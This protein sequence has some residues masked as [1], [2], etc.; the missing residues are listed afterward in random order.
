MNYHS[1]QHVCR[2]HTED[3]D[4]IL[5]G[6]VYV[7]T[8]IDGSNACIFRKDDGSVGVGSRNRELTPIMDNQGCASYVLSEPKFKMFLD[9]HPDCMLFG[10]WLIKVHIKSYQR[11][12][13]RKV[14][15]FDVMQQ[16]DDTFRYVPYEEYVPWLE[17]FGIEYI[18]LVAKLENPTEED[19]LNV[20]DKAY[21]LQDEPGQ[22]EGL[23]LKNYQYYNKYGRQTW[24]KIVREEFKQR[25]HEKQPK[26]EHELEQAIVDNFCTDAFIEKEY[27]K[28]AVDGWNSKLIPRLLGTVWHEFIVEESWNFIKKYKNP[29]VDF[30]VLNHLIIARVKEVKKEL[31]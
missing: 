14:Y 18:P 26:G 19:L 15:V 31:F 3:T 11:D 27:S 10:E 30:R 8:K 24:A 29:V 5:N 4:G 21:F 1:Y 12:A 17:E 13:W 16:V 28:L 20:M 25:K 9:K 22:N 6:T 2:L 7:T 23:V